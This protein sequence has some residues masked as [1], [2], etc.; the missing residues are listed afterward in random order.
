MKYLDP[1]VM[2]TSNCQVLASP[3]PEESY[4]VSSTATTVSQT[5]SNA[6]ISVYG[7]SVSALMDFITDISSFESK[8]ECLM[9]RMQQQVAA[10]SKKP[11]TS[12]SQ[13]STA[14]TDDWMKEGSD[15][16][17]APAS[18]QE[19]DPGDNGERGCV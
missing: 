9:S 10:G 13:S 16:A 3:P 8:I 5:S 17:T 6:A 2:P 14:T 18:P 11:S 12:F 7:T 15:A 1:V 4:D 19:S